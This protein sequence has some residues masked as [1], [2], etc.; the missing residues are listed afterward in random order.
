MIYMAAP[1]NVYTRN[2]ASDGFSKYTSRPSHM[3]KL[4]GKAHMNIMPI[5]VQNISSGDLAMVF[6]DQLKTPFPVG[7]EVGVSSF[8]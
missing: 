4:I 2:S 8:F 7:C 3:Q 5:C 6:I 1:V